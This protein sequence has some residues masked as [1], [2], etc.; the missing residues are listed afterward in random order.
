MWLIEPAMR[1]RLENFPPKKVSVRVN[2]LPTIPVL[3][4]FVG[5]RPKRVE[6]GE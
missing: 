6:L 1:V 5:N 4:E 3:K 2:I